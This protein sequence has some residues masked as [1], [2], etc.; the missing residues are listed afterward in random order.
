MKIKGVFIGWLGGVLLSLPLICIS[1]LPYTKLQTILPFFF[2]FVGLGVFVSL[3]TLAYKYSG[4]KQSIMRTVFMFIS[5]FVTV[6]FF[7]VFGL[8][9][10]VNC[11]FNIVENESNN[12]AAGVGMI[13]FLTVVLFA[14]VIVTILLSII[15]HIKKRNT[16]E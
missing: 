10:A 6:R 12:R 9:R 8:V 5:C 1:Y 16:G 14:C 13:Y 3:L 11:F 15:S 7:A 4:V 2:L